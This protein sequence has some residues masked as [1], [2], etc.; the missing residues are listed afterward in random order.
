MVTKMLGTTFLILFVTAII[1]NTF[2][3]FG[4]Y[5]FLLGVAAVIVFAIYILWIC[6]V[7]GRKE[8]D[9]MPIEDDPCGNDNI[10]PR[11]PQDYL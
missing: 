5:G 2:E 1:V 7:K 3:L 4:E 6:S 8:L 9:K 10:K 11:K